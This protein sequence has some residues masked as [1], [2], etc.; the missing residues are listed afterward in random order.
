[1]FVGRVRNRHGIIGDVGNL[2]EGCHNGV[3]RMLI[4]LLVCGTGNRQRMMIDH[5]VMVND[6]GG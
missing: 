2:G 4:Q 1:M 5:R 3:A 6:R